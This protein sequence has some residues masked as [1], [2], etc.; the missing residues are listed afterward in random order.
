M[1][2]RLGLGDLFDLLRK[3]IWGIYGTINSKK[4]QAR[5]YKRRQKEFGNNSNFS[6]RCACNDIILKRI[7][8]CRKKEKIGHFKSKLGFNFI[9][10]IIYKEEPVTTIMTKSFPRVKL[11]EQYSFL[12]KR[13]DLYL[14]DHK[15]AIEV[16]EKDHMDRKEDKEEERKDN[17]EK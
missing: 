15:L 3:E 13:I 4:E 9:N 6:F 7:M 5:E 11:I 14:P 8:H 2:K 17:I 12:G 1:Q 16:D 10:W